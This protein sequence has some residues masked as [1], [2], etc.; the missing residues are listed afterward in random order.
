MRTGYFFGWVMDG[1][2]FGGGGVVVPVN[3]PSDRHDHLPGDSNY[4]C[5]RALKR[6]MAVIREENPNTFMGPMCR[7]AQDL[8]LWSNRYADA[9]FTL[10]E[11]ATAGPLPGLSNLPMNVMYGDKIRKW[12]RSVCTKASFH[13]IWTSRRCLLHPRR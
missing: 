10:D 6:M 13:I 1:D 7:P 8:G 11:M 5:E 2:F 4:A 3:C 12:S 9:V